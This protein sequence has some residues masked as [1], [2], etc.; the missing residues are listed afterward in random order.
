MLTETEK[1]A[2]QLSEHKQRGLNMGPPIVLGKTSCFL[3]SSGI[4]TF[5][6]LNVDQ[7]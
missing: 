5:Y 6:L 1:D 2:P 7:K 4:F 3:L